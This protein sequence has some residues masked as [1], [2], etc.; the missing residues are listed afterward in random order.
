[1][2]DGALLPPEVDP[3]YAYFENLKEH[4]EDVFLAREE[5]PA[6]LL[7]GR[8]GMR[9]ELFWRRV[10]D[11]ERTKGSRI[12]RYHDVVRWNWLLELSEEDH[13]WL[14]KD[15][16]HGIDEESRVLAFDCL[17]RTRI[18]TADEADRSALVRRLATEN[19]LLDQHLRNQKPMPDLTADRG[20]QRQLRK[21]KSIEKKRD[22]ERESNKKTLETAIAEI[23]SGKHEGALQHLYYIGGPG[24]LRREIDTEKIQKIYGS[25]IAAAFLDGLRAFWRRASVPRPHEW[26]KPDRVPLAAV[27]GFAGLSLEVSEGLH[28]AGLDSELRKLALR[29][30]LWQPNQPPSWF[31]DLAVAEPDEARSLLAPLVKQE[32]E[33]EDDQLRVLRLDQICRLSLQGARAVIIPDVV[34]WLLATEPKRLDV[35]EA[36]LQCIEGASSAAISGIQTLAPLRCHASSEDPKRL[37]LWLVFWMNH[38]GKGAIDYLVSVL[39]EQDSKQASETVEELLSKIWAWGDARLP[40]SMLRIHQDAESLARLIPIAFL[41][42]PRSTDLNHESTYSPC[43]RDHAQD[44]RDRL[45]AWLSDLPPEQSLHLLQGLAEDPCLAEIRDYLLYRVKE[46]FS[47]GKSC[48]PWSPEH[49]VRW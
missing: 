37:A 13:E 27:L 25:A 36:A 45:I 22:D 28:L 15:S 26:K 21:M 48:E 47:A 18:S 20:Y 8:P 35:V 43:R 1:M 38:D 3:T 5:D 12:A 14:A 29:L 39:A 40:F 34:Q 49:V 11:A 31:S 6:T 7:Q 46:R 44:V 30:A 2:P 23:R 17:L 41:H 10:R 32:M 33:F 9:R 24:S 42:V 16:V 4:G 19:A